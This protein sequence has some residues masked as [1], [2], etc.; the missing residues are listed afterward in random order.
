MHG[1]ASERRFTPSREALDQFALSPASA[2]PETVIDD[3]LP[4]RVTLKRIPLQLV[5][6]VAIALLIVSVTAST[7]GA[8]DILPV[9]DPESS[10]ATADV[11]GASD[12]L[13]LVP[14]LGEVR[15]YTAGTDVLEV[16]ECPSAGPLTKTAATWV[17]EANAVVTPYYAWLSGGHYQPAFVVGG[18]VPPGQ[19]C[20]DWA[21]SHTT[22]TANA[23]VYI[24]NTSGGLATPGLDCS[25]IA[26]CPTRFPDNAREAYIGI[27]SS[28]WSTAAHEIGHMLHW[29]HSRTDPDGYQYDNAIDLMSGNWGLR[30]IGDLTVTGPNPEPYATTSLNRY[31][32]GWID[33]S[34]MIIWDGASHD[35]TLSSDPSS[36]L[37]ALVV[38]AGSEFFILD[39]RTTSLNDPI[40]G[41]WNGV[42]VYSVS[43]CST[44]WGIGGDIRQEPP[45]PFDQ[46]DIDAYEE[47]LAHV[48]GL[49]DDTEIGEARV[50]VLSRSASSYTVRVESK[51]PPTTFSDV[52]WTHTFRADV[53]WLA[54]AGITKGCNPS[55][56]NT[57]FCPDGPVT[58][59]QMA[60]FFVRALGLTDAGGGNHFTDDD[61]SI[62][63]GDIDRLV[64]AG[65]TRGCNPAAGGDR[66][67]P[68]RPVTRGEMAAFFVR[69]LG[70]TIDVG[71]VFVD[72]DG[73]IFEKDIQRLA[74]E[75]ITKGCNPPTNDR[76][77]PDA[78]IT[79]S[80]AAAFFHRAL[81]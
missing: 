7:A 31:A 16:W 81:G 78:S 48:L 74:A 4:T 21:R 17:T 8:S 59:G 36:G 62:F 80:Q 29:P 55:D 38:D 1:Q 58:R 73:S 10:E 42:E 68:D 33:P 25:R 57:Q 23:A 41:A 46:Y 37:Q 6:L 76:F 47:P 72:D 32:A 45:I 75:G 2:Y 27:S 65:I 77:C 13:G 61:T 9:A 52:P 66:F 51:W 60:A 53:E 64:T 35:L 3:H 54:E 5:M 24:T 19:S 49:G 28:I 12:P 11:T 20:P 50:T 39:A 40:P 30:A 71:D 26:S 14:E 15:R 70:L 22:G 18:T 34:Q 69:A 79:R 44:C 63:E 43:R 56:G 67:C